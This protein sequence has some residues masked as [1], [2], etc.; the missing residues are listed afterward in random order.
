MLRDADNYL[1]EGCGGAG[2]AC[3]VFLRV[4]EEGL[5][6]GVKLRVNMGEDQFGDPCLSG[7]PACVA[8]GRV[9][10]GVCVLA[11]PVRPER[12]VYQ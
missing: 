12:F 7:G 8:G 1:M 2:G 4:V 3:V 11:F 5:G 9:A 10:V 6:V